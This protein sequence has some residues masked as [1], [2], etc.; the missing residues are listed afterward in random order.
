MLNQWLSINN[1]RKYPMMLKYSKLLNW[2]I[3]GLTNQILLPTPLDHYTSTHFFSH[4][5]ICMSN[6]NEL[7]RTKTLARVVKNC[8]ISVDCT[9]FRQWLA[10][11]NSAISE[12]V[13]DN[14][15][16]QILFLSR[17]RMSEAQGG[18]KLEFG[19]KDSF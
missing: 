6:T 2:G 11:V 9:P 15:K 16:P 10:K 4:I 14:H 7:V 5:H 8:I 13:F 17:G 12:V 1:K 18:Y 3:T 19:L